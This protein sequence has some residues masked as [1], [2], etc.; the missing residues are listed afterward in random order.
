VN[1]R[2]PLVVAVCTLTLAGVGEA[3]SAARR[4]TVVKTAGAPVHAKP[5]VLVQELSIG[6]V[7][8]D[9][10]YMFGDVADLAVG[11]DGS[12]FV[13]DRKVPVVRQYDANGKFVRNVGRLG[14]GPGE[15]RSASG[16][17]VLKDGRLLLWDTGNW[18]V[19]VYS[20]KGEFV[21]QWLTPSGSANSSAQYSRA[22]MV[23]TAGVA[24]CRGT[25]IKRGPN[26]IE[27]RTVWL[28][29]DAGG[30]RDTVEPPVMPEPT[31]ML[32]ATAPGGNASATAGVPFLPQPAVA[33]SPL[34][35]FVTG[36]PSRY[37]FEI[38][39]EGK[40]PISIRRANVQPIAVSSAERES[41]RERIES[42]MK[43]TDPAWSW[44]G[45]EIPRTKPF[46][47]GLVVG[48]DGRIWVPVIPEASRRVGSISNQSMGVGRGGPPRPPLVEKPMPETAALYDLFE[49]SGAF[50]G[51][52]QVPPR[53]STVL[54][55]GDQVW[56]VAF[57]EDEVPSVKR[58]RIRWQ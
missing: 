4:D 52:V 37:A 15:Y 19:N 34:G 35:Y 30:I 32:S 17:A 56:A 13:L 10:T 51:S 9:E 45:P 55:K 24:W 1:T 25:V 26:G 20:P 6:V 16:L 18:R 33:L 2:H 8:G 5:G 14:S 53:V 44:N 39:A 40:A 27:R 36:M 43:R 58:Y 7:D 29:V 21:T 42:T 57:N 28:R 50:V 54:R 22:I 41:E 12:L 49:P 3:Q 11:N 48:L 23:D 46:Y 31:G 38:V 47:S